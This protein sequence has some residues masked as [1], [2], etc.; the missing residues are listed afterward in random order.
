MFGWGIWMIILG[1]GSLLLPMMGIQFRLMILL[2]PWQPLAGL[3]VAALGIVLVV[4][5]A[6]VGRAPASPRGLG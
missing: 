5:G 1:V 3:G 2:D 6:V 4:I